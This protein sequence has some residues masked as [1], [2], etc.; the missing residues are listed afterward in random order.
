MCSLNIGIEKCENYIDEFRGRAGIYT[1]ILLYTFPLVPPTSMSN[2][3][4][5]LF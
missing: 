4:I 2:F 5:Y 3:R 1:N